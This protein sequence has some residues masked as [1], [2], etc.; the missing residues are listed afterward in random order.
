MEDF[1]IFFLNGPIPA[2]F[3]LFLFFSRYNF[4]T[5]WKKHRW[6]AWDS[7]PGP[8]DGRCRRNHGAITL[9]YLMV[10]SL[11]QFHQKFI[12]WSLF[13]EVHFQISLNSFNWN[14]FITCCDEITCWLE[15]L[16]LNI[17]PTPTYD[18]KELGLNCWP[19]VQSLLTTLQYK[20]VFKWSLLYILKLTIQS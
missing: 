14:A 2:S 13:C 1:N 16:Y 5:N 10:C 3:C 11:I 15:L 6:C 4:N 19:L 20:K 17:G 8:Q 12:L 18:L 9:I 7:N